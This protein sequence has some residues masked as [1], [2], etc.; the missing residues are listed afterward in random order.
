MSVL[1]ICEKNSSASRIA[2]LLSDGSPDKS[3]YYK[4]PYFEFKR[5]G[6]DYVVMGLRGH[7]VEYDYPDKYNQWNKVEES[8]L[9]NVEPEKEVTASNIVS[10]LRKKGEDADMAIVATDYDREGELIGLEAV[11]LLTVKNPAMDVKRA[12]F[13]SLSKG[14]IERAF[15][16]LTDVDVNLAESADSRQLVDL[17]WG[18]VLTR[19]LSKAAG[20]Y[21]SN[22]ISAGRVQSPTLALVVDRDKEIED[23][24][25]DPYWKIT[26]ILEKDI[27]FEAKYEEDK[28]W[29]EER[30]EEI[31]E[32]VED[33]DE[34]LTISFEEEV[35]DRWPLPPFNTTQFLSEATKLG[36]SASQAMRTAENLYTAGWISYPRT[37]NT[38]YPSSL[39]Y[40]NHLEKLKDSELSDEIAELLEQKKI[41]ASHGKKKSKD[42]PPIYPIR[43]ATKKKLKGRDWKI[44]ELVL[45]R[46]MATVAP[47]AKARQRDAEFKIKD[48]KFFSKGYEIIEKGWIKYYPYY[49]VNETVVPSLEDGEHVKVIGTDLTEDETKPPRRYSQGG[50][51]REMEKLGLGT[52]STRHNIIQKLY[53]RGFLSGKTPRST[54]SGKGVIDALEGHADMVTKP[55][56]TKTLEEDMQKIA[57]G[58]LEKD[59][60][61]SESREMLEDVLKDLE[62]EKEDIG[63]ELKKNFRKQEAVGECPECGGTLVLRKSRKGRFVGCSNYPDCKNTYRIPKTGKIKPAGKECPECGAPKVRIYHHGDSE[64]LCVDLDCKYS[65]DKRYRGECPKC[66]G[67]LREIRSY[68]GKRFIGCSNYP[69]C[70]QT[71]PLPQNGKV[72]YEGDKCS[73]CGAPLIKIIKK[74]KP[75]W[76]L[77]PNPDCPS[78][79][80]SE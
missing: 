60:V 64:E 61:I 34:A 48:E 37:E 22:F 66:G 29:D 47:N 69:D 44:Y 57:E 1:V 24:E 39:N 53:N 78:K 5:D 72:I 11:K 7:I 42:H 30:A 56:M 65:R 33:A 46:F 4:I 32:K 8:E 31:F 79:D 19:F 45:R 71:Y 2:Y 28:I 54:H 9:I 58:E 52:K 43:P 68:R 27:E 15:S 10:L 77:C 63:K 6:E 21:G 17:A 3:Y 51:I 36:M 13:S 40:R 35:K 49:R 20:R 67:D 16:N 50:L 18:A 26:A 38:F 75:P 55:D 73:E 70:K 76:E 74:G 59:K 25:P 80:D 23:F 62:E 12:H 41:R 14:E